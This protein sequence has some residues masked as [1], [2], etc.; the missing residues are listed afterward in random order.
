M[1]S[2]DIRETTCAHSVS[3]ADRAVFQADMVLG[4]RAKAEERLCGHYYGFVTV[5]SIAFALR[6]PVVHEGTGYCGAFHE[7][8]LGHGV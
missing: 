8:S 4:P 1:R 2:S 5:P 7:G 3:L 6:R